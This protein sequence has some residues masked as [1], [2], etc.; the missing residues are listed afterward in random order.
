MEY[1][2]DFKIVLDSL[3]VLLRG[4]VVT[5]ELWTLAFV[6]GFTLGLIVSLGRVSGRAWVN[7][8]T[9]AYVELFRNTPVLVQLIWFYYAFPIVLGQQLSPFTAAAL[10]LTLNTSAYCA[11]IFRG[12]IVAIARGQWEGAKAIGMTRAMTMRRVIRRRC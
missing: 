1:S 7:G 4:L 10:A 11:E 6:L 8:P 12:G 5:V 2:W 3:P 9:I